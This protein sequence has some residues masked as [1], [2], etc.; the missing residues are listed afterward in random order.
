M[1]TKF[2][3]LAVAATFL[4]FFVTDVRP[5]SAVGYDFLRTFV[6]ARPSAMAGAFV[7]IPG[8]IHNIYYNPGG[9]AALEKRQGTLSYLNHLLDFQSGFLAFAQPKFDGTI[10]FGLHYFDYGQ[11]EGKD[12]ANNSTGTF[13]ANS[14]SLALGY[15]QYVLKNLSVGASAKVILFKIAEFSETALA[16][17]LGAVYHVPEYQLHLGLAVLNVGQTTSAFIETKDDLPTSVQ[18]GVAKKL[19]HLPLELSGAVVKFVEEDFN[20][21]L[22]GEFTLSDQL[23]LRLGYN[24]V[25]RDQRVDTSK[26]QIAGLSVGL[27]FKVNKFDI[28]YAFSSFGEVGSLNR[29]TLTGRF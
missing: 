18:L 14:W 1:R 8:D 19:E 6:G 25:G 22:G 23:F 15:S 2:K 11:F 5:Q 17:D 13:G 29:L 4:L 26:D 28:D 24:S 10:G 20:F 3:P 7:A 9:L 12:T 16:A 21:R 27:G